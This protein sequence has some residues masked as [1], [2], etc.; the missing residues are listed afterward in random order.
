MAQYAA[1][2]AS[3]SSR[4]ASFPGSSTTPRLGLAMAALAFSMPIFPCFEQKTP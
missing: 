3:A 1:S 2:P 4:A